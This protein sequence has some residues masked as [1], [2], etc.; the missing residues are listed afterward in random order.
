MASVA[1]VAAVSPA[2]GATCSGGPGGG[3]LLATAQWV[4]FIASLMPVAEVGR[5]RV[6]HS[7]ARCAGALGRY[8]ATC[9]VRSHDNSTTT[10]RCSAQQSG[11]SL[12]VHS[13]H[14]TSTS[15]I[16]AARIGHCSAACPAVRAVQST[17]GFL[18]L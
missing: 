7:A 3:G 14:G 16:H 8:A 11:S 2:G 18:V 13:H 17:G 15:P 10:G 1:R 12:R 5:H 4:L 6:C 9:V